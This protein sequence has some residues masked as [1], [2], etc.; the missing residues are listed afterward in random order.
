MR[1]IHQIKRLKPK[2]HLLD[3][4][5]LDFGWLSKTRHADVGHQEQARLRFQYAR[6]RVHQ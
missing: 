3:H 6:C 1:D 5:E 2:H 4:I